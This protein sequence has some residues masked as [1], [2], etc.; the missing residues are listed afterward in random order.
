MEA[1]WDSASNE[2]RA[3]ACARACAGVYTQGK[4]PSISQSRPIASKKSSCRADFF[5]DPSRVPWYNEDWA[6]A[7]RRMRKRLT[8]QVITLATPVKRKKR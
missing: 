4:P 6:I 5:L 1:R 8:P 7:R 2:T 3:R